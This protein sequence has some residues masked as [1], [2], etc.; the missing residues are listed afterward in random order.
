LFASL[1]A[2]SAPL[3]CP[4]S[5]IDIVDDLLPRSCGY[6]VIDFA[7]AADRAR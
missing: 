4:T 6:E 1:L 3:V 5:F 7:D 2:A